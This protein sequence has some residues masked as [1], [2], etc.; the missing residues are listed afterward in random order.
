MGF[1]SL[2]WPSNV[3]RLLWI[4]RTCPLCTSIE[5]QEAESHFLD[6]FLGL[7]AW[8]PVRCVNCFRRY[9]CFGKQN[10]H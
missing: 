10:R 2:H 4:R 3:P 6:R 8:R 7:I 9:Y 5:F 1:A